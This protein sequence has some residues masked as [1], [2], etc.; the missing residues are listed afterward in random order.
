[1]LAEGALLAYS[2]DDST[3]HRL[4]MRVTRESCAHGES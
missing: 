1:M 4:V 2:D 3:S